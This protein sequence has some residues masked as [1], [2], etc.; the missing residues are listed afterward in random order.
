MSKRDLAVSLLHQSGGLRLLDRWWGPER[1]TVLCYHSITDPHAPDYHLYDPNVSATP[2]MFARQMDYVKQH[3][4][5]IDL[6]ALS[7]HV[8]DGAPLPPRPLLITFDDGYHDNYTNAYPVLRE[9]GLPAVIFVVTGWMGSKQL[10]WWDQCGYLFRHTQQEH[11]DLP[12]IGPHDLGT[13]GARHQA[14]EAFMQR[15]KTSPE[16]DK[17]GHMDALAQALAVHV[18]EHDTPLFLTWEQAREL[19]ANGIACQ[20]HTVSHPILTRI[21][22]ETAR[23]EIAQSAAH[24]ADE[25]GQP[26]MAFAYT[27]GLINDYNPGIMQ[28]LRDLAIPLAFTLIPG[29]LRAEVRNRALEIPRVYLGHRDIFEMFVAKVMGIPA[30]LEQRQYHS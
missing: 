14:R 19:A 1:L 2:A 21:P 20:P 5:V 15:I 25:T 11:A 8:C 28:H 3:F 23:D 9:R 29:P 10:P 16:A 7:A 18:P 4:N 6:A 27:N 17:A 13:A 22:L 26:V 12:L 30:L 24:I